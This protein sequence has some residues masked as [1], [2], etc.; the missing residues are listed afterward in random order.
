MISLSDC[1][2]G[3]DNSGSGDSKIEKATGHFSIMQVSSVTPRYIGGKNS[4]DDIGNSYI[5]QTKGGK[6]IVIDGGLTGEADRLR[7]LLKNRY[8][9]VVD[10]WWVSHPHSD[11]I[12][13]MLD[14][15]KDPR[16]ITVKEVYHSR[17]PEALG[18]TERSTWNMYADPLYELL[19][20]STEIKTTDIQTPGGLFEIDGVLIKVL[21]VTNPELTTTEGGTSPYNN[22]S[23]ILR[24]WDDSKSFLFLGDAQ[25]ECGDK[26]LTK[27]SRFYKYLTVDYVQ[28][29][30]HGQQGVKESFYKSITFK[31][32]LW[33]T[34]NWVFDCW[35]ETMQTENT[36]TWMRNKG[37]GDN[38]WIVSCQTKDWFLE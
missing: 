34:P 4:P 21:G 6:V 12:G 20:N 9:G 33:P 38:N 32:V 13:A 10:Q 1:K 2:K 16:G 25:S 36:K 15:L 30:H 17:F 37:I 19:D 14:I 35:I 28:A 23:M 26:L 8:G 24:I 3:D 18:L 31:K 5:L 22:S 7:D 27:N 29:A 11:H